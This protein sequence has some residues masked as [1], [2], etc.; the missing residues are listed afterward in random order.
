MGTLEG[1]PTASVK[2]YDLYIR[3]ESLEK[4]GGGT[5]ENMVRRRAMLEEAV[6]E[7]PDFV[8]AWAAL[9]RLYDL[10]SDRLRRRG[11]YLEEGADRN[12]VEEELRLKSQRALEK[13]IALDPENV[14]TLLSRAVD[15]DWPKTW[16]EM[17]EHKAILNQVIAIQ[18][19]NA[20]AWYHLGF[21]HSHLRDFPDDDLEALRVDAEAAFEEA[22]RLDPFNARM[23]SAVLNWYRNNGF[24]ENVTR[25][26]ERL[27]QI[28]P[29]TADDRRLARVSWNFK[30]NQIEDAF[31]ETADESLIED[32]EKGWM[33]AVETGDL[34]VAHSD[35]LDERTLRNYTND[36][37]RLLEVS[38]IPVDPGEGG[39][40]PHVFSL[41]RGSAIAFHLIQGNIE[42]ARLVAQNILEQEQA[43]LAQTV[44]TCACLPAS[45]SSAYA[46]TGNIEEAQRWAEELLEERGPGNDWVITTMA[47]I[48]VERAV[49]I[50]FGELAINGNTRL[51]DELAAYQAWNRPFLAHPR[52][53]EYYLKEGKWIDYLAARVPEYAEYSRN[54]AN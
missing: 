7:D 15:H 6:T 48:D 52:V 38:L 33:H 1:M 14:E 54:V 13:A 16:E 31:L 20:K 43:I 37:D 53:Q 49:E 39:W 11:W 17:Q 4:T 46:V 41:L 47:H 22:L 30:A 25:L 12:Q 35:Y 24:Q 10:Q 50:A 19:D 9:K 26:S 23:V 45:L 51:F 2:A 34:I 29:E 5:E 27:N 44:S 40:N 3:A 18:P 8:E 36:L 21:W 32:Y 42:Q 28:I